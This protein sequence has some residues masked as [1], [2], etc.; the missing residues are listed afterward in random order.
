MVKEDLKII[1]FGNTS[2]SKIFLKYLHEVVNYNV[3]GVVTDPDK[4]LRKR[5]KEI[6]SVT[7][8]KEYAVEN[9]IS[10]LP[11]DA[12]VLQACDANL[13]VVVAYKYLQKN[14]WQIPEYGTINIHPSLLPEFRGAAPIEHALMN[15]RTESGVT[16]FYISEDIDS[17]N[18]ITRQKVDLPDDINAEKAYQKM[19]DA[20]TWCLF[21]ALYR[22]VSENG[23]PTTDSQQYLIPTFA[24]KIKNIKIDWSWDHKKIYDYVR[25]LT[26]HNG[27][28]TVIN[29]IEVRILEARMTCMSLWPKEV[30]IYKDF[31]A[32]GAG[33]HMGV[34][35][36]KVKPAGKKEMRAIDFINGLKNKTDKIEIT[37]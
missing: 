27:P 2:F 13:Y 34:E 9:N 18:I 10:V 16:C 21:K 12:G 31:V 15:G 20:G 25:A 17:G 1:F 33:N 24:P 35:L 29:G 23:R 19:A 30:H 3:V 28:Y 22:I 14:I 11:H 26:F 7:P 36:L 6:T 4:V 8:V 32:I 5:K 37:D